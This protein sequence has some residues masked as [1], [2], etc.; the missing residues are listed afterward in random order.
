M[1][2]REARVGEGGAAL[3][4]P[5]DGRGV[6]ALGIG[7]QVVDIAVAAGT[8]HHRVGQVGLDLAGDQIASDDPARPAVDDDEVEHLGAREH[9]DAARAHLPHQRLVGAEEQ[10]LAGLPAGIER[11]GNQR[12]A[13]GAVGQ[14]AAILAGEG[15]TLG[16]ALVDD[17]VA[18][19]GE[20]VH[21]GLAGAE[22]AALDR[23][24]EEAEDA[25]AIVLVGLGGVDAALGGDAVGAPG[26][27]LEAK[28]LDVVAELGEGG[29]GRAAGQ[30][31]SYHDD[32]VFP[33]VGRADQ[34][35]VE[36][37]F[38]PGLL[39]GTGGDSGIQ[40]HSRAP[41][42]PMKPVQTATGIEILPAAMKMAKPAERCFRIGVYRG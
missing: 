17:V 9:G 8:Q 5:P 16:D 36:L 14:R 42:L 38:V 6:A 31:G 40:F 24:V 23:V 27:V 32:A 4:G 33:L 12:A 26:A 3:I 7:R 15:H 18:D 34:L 2:L 20:A 37:A 19:L 22:V 25:I 21:V 30:A 39:N 28:T 13:E 41:Q 11:A 10:L 29:R 35:H 1:D